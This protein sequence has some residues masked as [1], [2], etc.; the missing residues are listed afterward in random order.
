MATSKA[1]TNPPP[2]LQGTVAGDFT[3]DDLAKRIELRAP[4]GKQMAA[5][6]RTRSMKR[7][8][9]ACGEGKMPSVYWTKV[10]AMS[11]ALELE[12]RRALNI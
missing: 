11:D 3:M 7:G 8:A 6:L 10:L 2:G 12:M 1:P 9:E 4:Y 5:F